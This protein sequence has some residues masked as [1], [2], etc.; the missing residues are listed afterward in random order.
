MSMTRCAIYLVVLLSA[1]MMTAARALPAESPPT[2]PETQP[3]K[4]ARSG[5]KTGEKPGKPDEK[6]AKLTTML[7]QL[8]KEISAVR[9]LE[10]KSPVVAKII[11]RPDGA[12]KGIRGKYE[13]KNKTL[14]VYDDVGANYTR[15]VLIHE[16]IHALQDQHFNF[17]RLHRRKLPDDASLALS[18][19]IEGDATLTM[20]ELLKKTQPH[21]TKILDAPLVG[22]RSRRRAFIYGAGARYVDALKK[23]GGWKGVNEKFKSPP[24]STAEILHVDRVKRV[25]L[26]AGVTRGELGIL[27]QLAGHPKTAPLAV[28]AAAGWQGDRLVE[29]GP[30]KK[31]TVAFA[32][33][34]DA[35]EFQAA[36][37]AWYG[38][39]NPKLKSFQEKA[40]SNAWRGS[41]G[42]VVALRRR[43]KRVLVLEAP[44]DGAY[45]TLVDQ[46]EGSPVLFVRAVKQ[47]RN[48]TFG[49]LV[50]ALSAGDVVCV[51]ELHTSEIHHRLQLQ[52]I[53]A[54]FARDERLGVGMEVFQ[55]PFQDGIDRYIRHEID[56]GEFLRQSEYAKRWSVD[57]SLYRPIVEFCRRNGV[58][59]AALNAPKELTDRVS[60]VGYAKLTEG[61][62]KKLGKIDFQVKAHRDFWL[63][64]LGMI[65]GKKTTAQQQKAKAQRAYQVMTVWDERM[66]A[67]AARFQQ[68]R[69]IR[70]MVVLAGSSHFDH[71][72]GIPARIAKRTGGKVITV[73]IDNLAIHGKSIAAKL[74]DYI[75]VVR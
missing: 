52:V 11:P 36:I 38:A 60:K 74:A 62:K 64:R 28:K 12:R 23:R 16:M 71:Y 51:G 24:S 54:L 17:R 50:D 45:K 27:D 25:N 14:T 66:A 39:K 33:E 35:R 49:Q 30:L 4:Q 46:I 1:V 75:V 48:I 7:R 61:E 15:S 69:G 13:F 18:A 22:G 47:R 56:E 6:M 73:R 29:K 31:W 5:Q 21:I 53:K 63:P 72:F 44:D 41:K 59:I 43:G 34:K 10:F 55:E 42:N 70:R 19:L 20:I 8:E 37:A 32:T 40:R 2:R 68:D 65:H 57:W 26:G 67:N 58:P 9:G 3:A